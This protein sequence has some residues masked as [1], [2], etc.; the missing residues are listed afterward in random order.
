MRC[1]RLP[2][3]KENEIF[4][5]LL[6]TSSKT[7]NLFMQVVPFQCKTRSVKEV[8]VKYTNAF[9]FTTLKL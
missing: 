1:R 3:E 5:V 4:L 9:K 7:Q 2:P 8:K 6:E